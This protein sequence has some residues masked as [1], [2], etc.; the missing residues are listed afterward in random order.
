MKHRPFDLRRKIYVSFDGE[1]GLDYGGV[2]REWFFLLSHEILNPKLKLF[3]STESNSLVI[4]PSSVEVDDHITKFQFIGRIIAMSLYHGKLIDTG[5]S[6]PFYKKMLKKPL[7]LKDLESIDPTLYAS[8]H[9]MEFAF[10]N[11]DI[12]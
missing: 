3:E 1:E 10:F 11:T 7:C 9:W 6:L 4:S 5:F 8:L 12:N 2:A